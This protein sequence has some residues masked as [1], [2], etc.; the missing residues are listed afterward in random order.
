MKINFLGKECTENLECKTCYDNG[1]L[2]ELKNGYEYGECPCLI[3]NCN[4]CIEDNKCKLCN[5]KLARRSTV[6]TD[7]DVCISGTTSKCPD[8]YGFE[9]GFKGRC[10][11]CPEGCDACDW[12]TP[13]GSCS[14]CSDSSHKVID[15]SK[16]EYI[17]AGDPNYQVTKCAA[18][19]T[20]VK[21]LFTSS[22]LEYQKCVSKCSQCSDS[23]TCT[24]CED[25]NNSATPMFLMSNE[26]PHRCTDC[27]QSNHEFQTEE[28]PKKCVVCASGQ[29]LM[30]G[31]T[32]SPDCLPCTKESSN[33]VDPDGFCQDC[34]PE[35]QECSDK[36]GC[37]SCKD[38][39]HSL[40]PDK[41]C[42]VGC[43]KNHK[44]DQE[45]VCQPLTCTLTNCDECSDHNICSKCS[46][47]FN[48]DSS[49]NKCEKEDEKENKE[50]NEIVVD[51]IL[52]QISNLGREREFNFR[53]QLE[54]E[55]Y[56]NWE[57]KTIMKGI[58]D[59]V[60]QATINIELADQ[61]NKRYPTKGLQIYQ[62]NPGGK[63]QAELALFLSFD[64]N[65]LQTEGDDLDKETTEIKLS[66][67]YL[68]NLKLRIAEDDQ[69]KYYLS[70]I[71]QVYQLK[72][73]VKGDIESSVPPQIAALGKT[74]GSLSESA[75]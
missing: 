46:L 69:S 72:S 54:E 37:T 20:V 73:F 61:N 30:K 52:I 68:S 25:S 6:T 4:T 32:S 8:G 12:P 10:V 26:S 27:L 55:K 22:A 34:L 70:K 36:N 13:V 63:T 47:G 33:F 21:G 18:P 40:Q 19:S 45:R 15:Y 41:T 75:G 51:Y 64:K 44:A 14:A 50:K 49:K 74:S 71:N 5:N 58:K 29:R 35:C 31:G 60:N 17:K 1:A 9:D 53:I 43:P 39:I 48:L 65:H 16:S 24:T 66:S 42:S 57:L 62:S 23:T 7:K 56:T 38:P 11:K 59:S 2:V 28:T 67:L 3:G